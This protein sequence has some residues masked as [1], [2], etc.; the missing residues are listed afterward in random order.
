MRHLSVELSAEG[1]PD[2]EQLW[3]YIRFL[4]KTS[5]ITQIRVFVLFGTK[6]VFESAVI[7]FRLNW[8]CWSSWLLSFRGRWLGGRLLRHSFLSALLFTFFIDSKWIDELASLL[9]CDGLNE[10]SIQIEL[11]VSKLFNIILKQD[12]VV[13]VTSDT[14]RANRAHIHR[15]PLRCSPCGSRWL[16]LAITATC[17]WLLSIRCLFCLQRVQYWR[18]LQKFDLSCEHCNRQEDAVHR[19]FALEWE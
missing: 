6:S 3:H 15:G 17:W 2:E 14:K 12:R 16:V 18:H 11:L 13:L 7:N 9:G 4:V 19:E 5:K 1:S 8:L 10:T